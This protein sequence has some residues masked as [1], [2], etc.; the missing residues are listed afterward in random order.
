MDSASDNRVIRVVECIR[1]DIGLSGS[2]F[3]RD[4]YELISDGREDKALEII[5]KIIPAAAER[6]GLGYRVMRHR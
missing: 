4:V 5:R 6:L 3:A 2:V 1:N